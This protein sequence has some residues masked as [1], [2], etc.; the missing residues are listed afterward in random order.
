MIIDIMSPCLNVDG[1]NHDKSLS[2]S[3]YKAKE[4]KDHQTVE[5]LYIIHSRSVE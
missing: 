1:E 3:D 5:K 4:A 2:N